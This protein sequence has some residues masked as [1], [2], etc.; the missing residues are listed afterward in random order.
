[1]A[2]ADLDG[3]GDLDVVVNNLNGNVSLYRNDATAPRITVRLRG[4]GANRAGIGA[5][6]EVNGGGVTQSQEMIAGGRYLSSDDAL[7]T[8]AALGKSTIT[9]NWRSGAVSKLESLDQDQLVEVNEPDAER[10]ARSHAPYQ[11]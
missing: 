6:I 5:K 9:V 1:M 3:D 11:S 8:F 4:R 10:R 7:R 2:L